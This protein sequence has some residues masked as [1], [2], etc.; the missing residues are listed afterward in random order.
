VER[1]HKQWNEAGNREEAYTEALHVIAEA[2]AKIAS[3]AENLAIT[4]GRCE[5]AATA[6][7][8]VS[9]RSSFIGRSTSQRLLQDAL[10]A[11]L[12]QSPSC[13]AINYDVS[14]SV[15][16]EATVNTL[17]TARKGTRNAA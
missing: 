7:S 5:E 8:V 1:G 11:V 13:N 15:R 2:E 10:L 14:S 16:R 3:A 17:S 6:F 12:S 4:A 9:N